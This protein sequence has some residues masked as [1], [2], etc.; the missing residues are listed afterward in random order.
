M[1]CPNSDPKFDKIFANF[2]D[3]S[4]RNYPEARMRAYFLV[5]IVLR[6]FLYALVYVYRDKPWMPVVVGSVALFAMVN[7]WESVKNPGRQWWSKRFQFGVA[8]VLFLSC[9]ALYV[10]KIDSRVPSGILFLSL[11]GGISQAFYHGFC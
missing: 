7:L 2:T 9:V 1:S 3:T 11:F 4:S 10:G 6:V 8:V 5:C